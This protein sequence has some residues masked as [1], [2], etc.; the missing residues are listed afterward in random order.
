MEQIKRI[1]L[2]SPEYKTGII[3][4]ILNLRIYNI[5]HYAQIVKCRYFLFLSGASPNN[6]HKNIQQEECLAKELLFA[7]LFQLNISFYLEMNSISFSLRS[8]PF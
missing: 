7:H 2:L 6:L 5:S 8:C 1:E 3:A 4:S